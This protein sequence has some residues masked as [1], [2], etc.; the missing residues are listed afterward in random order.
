MLR[1]EE[2]WDIAPFSLKREEK[3]AFLSQRLQ[4]LTRH[5]YASCPPYQRIVDGLAFDARNL[6]AVEDYPFIP[7]RLFKDYELRSIR[8]EDVV[9]TM[10]SS[11]TSGQKVSR[12]FLD[13][14]A[15]ANQV[16][17]LVKIASHF[18]GTKRMPLLVIDSPST[19][20]DRHLFSARGAGILGF[21]VLGTDVTYALDEEMRINLP[22]I[23]GFLEKHAH[24][25]LFLFGFTS[26][27]WEHFYAHFA[28]A[29]ERIDLA[30]GTLIHGGGWKTLASQSVDNTAF[31]R[32]LADVLNLRRVCNY[33]GM[34]E[35][36]GSIFMEG[37]CGHLHC[38][39]FSDVIVRRED[40][41]V[42]GVGEPG[43]IQVISVLPTS[44][45]GH[46]LLTEDLGELLGEDDCPC[47][48]RGKYFVVHG[49]IENAEARGC[50]DTYQRR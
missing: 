20:K 7:V 2:L 27:V 12:I 29:S 19:V 39:I 6:V 45:P 32:S 25:N 1:F 31:K 50:S 18:L 42:C 28:R 46:N 40:L 11:G 48:L 23:R 3:R 36:T 14:A 47:G 35:Q 16:K 15:A 4:E 43:L 49:R 8:P 33:Y 17:T 10:T 24:E 26:I 9:K 21:S 38:S 44:Y 34:V 22:V 30:R 13:K 37:D 5:H 41:S